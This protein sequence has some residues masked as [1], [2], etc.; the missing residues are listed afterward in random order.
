MM[1]QKG[2]YFCKLLYPTDKPPE[3]I[4]RCSQISTLTIFH[5]EHK[6]IGLVGFFVRETDRLM[7]GREL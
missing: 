6:I 4:A 5:A 3:V 1:V 2:T 7:S